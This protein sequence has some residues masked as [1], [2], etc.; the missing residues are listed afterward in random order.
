MP[1][2]ELSSRSHHCYLKAP[3]S[4]A[5]RLSPLHTVEARLLKWTLSLEASTYLELHQDVSYPTLQTRYSN[6][7]LIIFFIVIDTLQDIIAA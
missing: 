1:F 5:P 3:S 2:T 4:F 6:S 7:I